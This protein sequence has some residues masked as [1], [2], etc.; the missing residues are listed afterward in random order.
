MNYHLYWYY[1]FVSY[2]FLVLDT[3][4]CLLF[5]VNYR[6]WLKNSPTQKLWFLRNA[7]VFLLNFAYLLLAYLFSSLHISSWCML[8]LLYMCQND[9]N[10]NFSNEFCN[11]TNI[12]FVKEL[13]MSYGLTVMSLWHCILCLPVNKVF[14]YILQYL[15]S[16]LWQLGMQLLLWWK[17]HTKIRYRFGHCGDFAL[18]AKL[19][20]KGQLYSYTMKAVC[21]CVDQRSK[22][23][24]FVMRPKQIDSSATS[25]KS[26]WDA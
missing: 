20:G 16:Y 6:V 19:L 4:F 24:S 18:D 3:L 22:P 25:T 17:C 5:A 12:D 1:L 26:Y 23:K 14:S 2:Y 8:Y 10:A 9:G 11:V 13:V 21:K 15:K 7:S